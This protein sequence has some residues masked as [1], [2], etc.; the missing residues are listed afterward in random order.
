MARL[1]RC[2][3]VLLAFAAFA[4]PALAA[5]DRQVVG[6]VEGRTAL[7]GRRLTDSAIP[8]PGALALFALGAAAVAAAVRR[9]RQA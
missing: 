3:F 7:A 4:G 6:P 1:T 2:C 5:R 9:S 8:E